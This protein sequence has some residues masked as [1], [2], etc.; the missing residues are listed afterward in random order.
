M[1]YLF[2]VKKCLIGH[3]FISIK[4]IFPLPV[5]PIHFFLFQLKNDSILAL[6]GSTVQKESTF[7]FSKFICVFGQQ[8]ETQWTVHYYNSG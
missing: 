5:E 4:F 7:V 3:F 8:I 6:G 1:I 2:H